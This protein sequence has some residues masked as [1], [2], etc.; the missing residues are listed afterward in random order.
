MQKNI[1]LVLLCVL[2]VF[3]L[4]LTAVAADRGPQKQATSVTT[5]HSP[6][7]VALPISDTGRFD[8]AWLVVSGSFGGTTQA[9]SY[10][11]GTYTGSVNAA[12][13][14]TGIIPATNIPTLFP[15]DKFLMTSTG[16]GT[17]TVTVT[18][19]GRVFD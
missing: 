8:P 2:C 19:I 13:S 18:A 15:G 5:N 1:A 12:V 9:V 17:N 3:V 11:S 10:V 4:S 16:L 6:A 14:A 7:T